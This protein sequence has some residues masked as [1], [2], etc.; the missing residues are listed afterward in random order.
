MQGKQY[1]G[2]LC[3]AEFSAK[4]AKIVAREIGGEV[5]F[6]DPMAY[7]WFNNLR[8]VAKKFIDAL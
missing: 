8:Y 4:C 7:E 6:A 5:I 1:K 3:S 2:Y